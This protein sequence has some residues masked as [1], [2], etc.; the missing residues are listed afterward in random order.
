MM[1]TYTTCMLWAWGSNLRDKNIDDDRK[2]V[3][4]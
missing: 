4:P 2:G 3:E 1:I